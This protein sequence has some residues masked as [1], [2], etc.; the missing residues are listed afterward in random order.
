MTNAD[1]RVRAILQTERLTEQSPEMAPIRTER[2]RVKSLLTEAFGA[3][4]V[5]MRDGGSK[6]KNT[7][8][9]RDHDLDMLYY[10]HADNDRV[11]GTLKDIYDN[12]LGVLAYHYDFTPGT[13]A[14]RL[15][16]KGRA[17]TGQGL[18]ID[19]VAG[20]FVEGS[21]GNV[22]LHQADGEK[23]RLMTNPDVHI[24]HVRDFHSH[25]AVCACKLWRVANGVRVKQF[26]FELLCIDLLE[27]RR[28]M[29]LSAQVAAVLKD[30][31]RM[32]SAPAI[33]DPANSGNNVSKLLTGASW[34]DLQAAADHSVSLFATHGWEEIIPA[35]VDVV[36]APAVA[37]ASVS[38]GTG[39]KPWSC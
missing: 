13:T 38:T 25:E 29:G 27:A 37:R 33:R 36:D 4:G 26:A 7:M 2:E 14:V 24:A 6:A 32:Q 8:L 11:G 1:Q 10:A 5:S 34:A 20:R 23:S 19:V 18:R 22:F 16:A 21:S 3:S 12:V 31:G 15:F 9:K 28:G 35:T 17:R 39:T 30:I